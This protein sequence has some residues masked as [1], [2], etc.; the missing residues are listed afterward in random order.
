ML[1]TPPVERAVVNAPPVEYTA[2][3]TGA[4]LFAR[5]EEMGATLVCG[6]PVELMDGLAIDRETEL[7]T[8]AGMGPCEPKPPVE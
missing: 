3:P 6:E 5:A 1:P 4:E 8:V 2:L 7:L